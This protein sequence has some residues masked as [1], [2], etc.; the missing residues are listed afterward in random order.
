MD[1][2]TL[3]DE[4]LVSPVRAAMQPTSS[5]NHETHLLGGYELQRTSHT[6]LCPAR[7]SIYV[8]VAMFDLQIEPFRHI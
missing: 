7:G 5:V 2:A 3:I 4:A 8:T 1:A 6:N